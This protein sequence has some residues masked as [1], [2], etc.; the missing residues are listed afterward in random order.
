MPRS[1]HHYKKNQT[2]GRSGSIIAIITDF[3]SQDQYA[4]VMKGVMLSIN[5]SVKIVDITHEIQQ[6][7]IMQAGYLLWSAYKYFPKRTIFICVVDPG[8]GSKRRIV[9]TKAGQYIFLAPD[10]GLLDFIIN[11]E[12]EVK[13]IELQE[14]DLKKFLFDKVSATFH[15]RDVFAPLGGHLSKGLPLKRLGAAAARKAGPSKFVCSQT[16]VIHPC[17]LH[18]D[19]FGNVITNIRVED[20]EQAVRDLKAISIG[21]NLVSRWVGCYD[22]APS[23]SPC[24]IVGSS[25]LAEI[26]IKNNNAARILKVTF[27]APVKIYWQ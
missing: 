8:V 16:D 20:T 26:F 2:T 27:D 22:E 15:G 6:H 9:C 21:T 10:N 13:E 25:G 17:I 3:G 5:P 24:L 19:R 23:N 7:N 18:I 14:K 1:K 11:E 12:K 4:A